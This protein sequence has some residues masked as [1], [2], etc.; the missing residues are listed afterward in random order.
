M[1]VRMEINTSFHGCHVHSHQPPANSGPT[2]LE[3]QPNEDC[4][5]H[6]KQYMHELEYEWQSNLSPMIS[7]SAIIPLFIKKKLV[8]NNYKQRLLLVHSSI[9]MIYYLRHQDREG[10]TDFIFELVDWTIIVNNLTALHKFSS[11]KFA[12][13]I[14]FMVDIPNTE[15]QKHKHSSNRKILPTTTWQMSMLPNHGE[16]KIHLHTYTHNYIKAL[17]AIV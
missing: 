2:P 7:P 16:K 1:V 11:S 17:W 12:P 6:T 4:D 14:K 10:W 9:N 8:T 15:Y 13:I 5:E 3:I